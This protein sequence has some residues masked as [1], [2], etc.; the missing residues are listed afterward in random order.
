MVQDYMTNANDARWW[1]TR[2]F[3]VALVLLSA[4]PL[5]W[6][7]L[8]PL[9][10]LPGHMGRWHIAMALPTSPDLQRFYA[11]DWALIPNL[12][13]DLLV[14]ALARLV[15]FEPATKLAVI[16][17]PILTVT[18]L[19]WTARE[20]H[21]RIPP[22]AIFALPLA[23]AWP[24]QLGFVNFAL[25]QA[26]ALCGLALWIR[27]GRQN[28][29]ILRAMLFV[30]IAC[31]VWISHS[32]GWG[33]LGLMAAGADVARLR[34]TGRRWPAA[35]VGAAIQCLSMTAP[36]FVMLTSLQGGAGAAGGGL[37]A[38]DWFNAPAKLIWLVSLFRDRWPWFDL[39]S[40]LPLIAILYGGMRSS[41]L[42]FSPLLGIAALLCL[43]AFVI[44]PRL[45]MGGAYVDMRMAP[46]AL[47]LGLIAIVPRDPKV[48]RTLAVV[49]TAFLIMRLAGTTLSFAE[50]SAEHQRELAAIGAI[51]HGAAVLSLVSLPCGGAWDDLRRNHLP[52]MAIVRRDVFTNEQWAL[53]GQQL[54]RVRYGQATPYL[55]DPSQIVFPKLCRSFGSDFDAT[56][57]G[58]PRTAFTHVWTIG[59]APGAAKARDLRVIWTNGESTL[60]RVVR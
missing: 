19:L 48:S 32:F 14:P 4:V 28:R 9:G 11:Y 55:A 38:G 60:Y 25:S 37:D 45:L 42:G 34:A 24:F 52:G 12:G 26:L 5:L 3:A 31:A 13:M 58:F 49:A 50:R 44:L 47:M 56:I 53:K 10:D 7:A 20:A 43:A 22:T 46:A 1:E 54:L 18:G 35:L 36:L 2:A 39:L 27:L 23:Y 21:G 40:L 59:F 51:P 15:G 57:A 41:R 30:P 29:L 17:I 6:P 33:L 16:A 8:P